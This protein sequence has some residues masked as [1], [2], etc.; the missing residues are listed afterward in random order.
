MISFAVL[1]LDFFI[2]FIYAFFSTKFNDGLGNYISIGALF[3]FFLILNVSYVVIKYL[4]FKW[5]HSSS[6]GRIKG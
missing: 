6:S 2:W 4:I 3:L 5:N 1:L